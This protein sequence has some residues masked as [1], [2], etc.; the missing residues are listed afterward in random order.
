MRT[1]I[2]SSIMLADHTGKH[3]IKLTRLYVTVERDSYKRSPSNNILVGSDRLL[4][5]SLCVTQARHVTQVCI[6]RANRCAVHRPSSSCRHERVE[7]NRSTVKTPS[8]ISPTTK[9]FCKCRV[10]LTA[11]RWIREKERER[12]CVCLYR[13][14]EKSL[15]SGTNTFSSEP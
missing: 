14:F 8:R 7:Q 1:A 9:I 10:K 11:V 2:V 5:V 12:L 13:K 6:A 3:S 15:K 4:F